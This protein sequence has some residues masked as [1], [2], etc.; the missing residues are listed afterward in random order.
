MVR[1]CTGAL[2]VRTKRCHDRVNYIALSSKKTPLEKLS[3][4]GH[5]LSEVEHHDSLGV[6][7]PEPFVVFDFDAPS[8]AAI[9]VKLVDALSLK[10][11]M[12]KT[13]RGVHLWFKSPAPLKNSI[14]VRSAIGTL[15]DV[16]S[17]GK[18]SYVMVKKEGVWREWLKTIPASEV[19]EVPCWLRP[20]RYPHSFK[21][22]KAGDGR[23]QGLYEYILAL[24]GKGFSKEEI[25][26]TLRII[27][28]YVF[29]APLG[30]K[31]METL[32]RDEAFK[33]EAK[34]A[35]AVDL[36][37]C[38]RE[39]G[40]LL[41]NEFANLL[42]SGMNILTVNGLCYVYDGGYY[43]YA[44]RDIERAMIDLYPTVKRQQRSE[45]LDYIKIITHKPS[46][47][48]DVPEYIINLQNCRLDVRTGERLPFSPDVLDFVRIPVNYEPAVYHEALDRMLDRVF[49]GDTQVRALFEEMVGYILIRNCR[50]RKGFLFYGSGS[51]GKSTI[52][53]LLKKFIG[54][55][56]VSTI[57]MEKLADRF[58]TA[59]LE[60][61][62]ANIGD[63]IS[64]R[65]IQDTGT[66]KK[67]FTGESVTVERKGQDPFT[68]KSHAKMIFSTNQIPRIA[69]RS[70]GMYSRLMLIPFTACFQHT[71]KDFDP[72]IEDKITT[73]EA[74]SYLLNLGLKGILRVL[75]QNR[76]TSPRV[77]EKAL[78]EFERDQST[79]LTWVEEE[80]VT[81]EYL[82][83]ATTDELYSKFQDW[84]VRAG[85]K[86]QVSLRTFHRDIEERYNFERRRTRNQDT[87]FR[88]RYQFVVN[89]R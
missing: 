9:M 77:V 6:L 88:Y 60:N 86:H 40:A 73:P 70:R 39:D 62:L 28:K 71:D 58:K 83:E 53:N 25:R 59:E 52:L 11:L 80:G 61:K 66:I 46:S 1:S 47:E 41:H 31:E 79:V 18:L 72:F 69:D 38:F 36:S 13:S 32:S 30:D 74:F 89:L 26:E 33:P 84:C 3:L 81:I 54:D 35:K 64:H 65:E 10:C 50:F 23:N 12:M 42:V 15:Y 2:N 22:L 49:N 20:V 24:Q 76:F 44:E 67:L 85:L 68:L 55:A 75:A 57:E 78:E 5:P 82:T 56:N 34:M 29:A 8:D 43:R 4:G 14:K 17:Y 7:I 19:D 45:V 48:I 63:D 51:N 21:G 37:R 16:R 27:N 87:Q